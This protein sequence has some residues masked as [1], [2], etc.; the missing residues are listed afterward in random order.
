MLK[1]Q[2]REVYKTRRMELSDAERSKLDDLMLI[3][4]Q[5]LE[6][7]F[8]NSILTYWPIAENHEPGTHIFTEFLKFRNPSLE[9]AYPKM[10]KGDH[11]M[12]AIAVNEDTPFVKAGFNVPEPVGDHILSPESFDLVFVPMLICDMNGYRVGYGKGFYDQYLAQC[13]S[14]CIKAGL[15]YFPPIDQIEDKDH[16][17]IPL[18]ICITPQQ[19]YVF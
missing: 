11:N 19:S 4:F 13:R 12:D 1:A 2:A 16:F 7:P 10:N 9:I 15:C 18:N 3:V 14:D 6:L 8:L 5:K 17:D